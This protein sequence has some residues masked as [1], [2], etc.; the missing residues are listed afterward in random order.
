MFAQLGARGVSVFFGSG[1]E[2]VGPTV[3]YCVTNDGK[4]TTGEYSVLANLVSVYRFL[5]WIPTRSRL[6]LI[7]FRYPFRLLAA[8][9]FYRL[10]AAFLMLSQNVSSSVSIN[11]LR[12]MLMKTHS[13]LHPFAITT[14]SYHQRDN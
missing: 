10:K 4:N 13:M 6:G 8:K 7:Y 12:D 11:V 9:V 2:G 14:S 1:D 3:E 5:S